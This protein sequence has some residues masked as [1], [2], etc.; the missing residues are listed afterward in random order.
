MRTFVGK[1]MN[2][3]GHIVQK[4]ASSLENNRFENMTP[5]LCLCKSVS[6]GQFG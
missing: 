6:A 5:I 3:F 1:Q 2:V 4:L